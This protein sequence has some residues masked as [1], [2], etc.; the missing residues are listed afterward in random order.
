MNY[1]EIKFYEENCGFNEKED[2]SAITITSSDCYISL[3]SIE[4]IVE[5][6]VRCSIHDAMA[7]ERYKVTYWEDT[8][9]LEEFIKGSVS[10]KKEAV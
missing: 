8:D 1:K 6:V 3:D 5:T 2:D 10:K 9:G 7:L 4:K